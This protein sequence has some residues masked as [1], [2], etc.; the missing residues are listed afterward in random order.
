[1]AA[2][3]IAMQ[4]RLIV[5]PAAQLSTSLAPMSMVM[6]AILERC[7]L[8]IWRYTIASHPGFRTIQHAM[9]D[10]VRQAG[11]GS[12]LIEQAAAAPV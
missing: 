10:Y 2:T 6:S 3:P 5:P 11:A 4:L 9:H 12:L 8:K 7:A 1:M